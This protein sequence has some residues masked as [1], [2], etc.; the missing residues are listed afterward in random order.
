M[1]AYELN[2]VINRPIEE[3]FTVLSNLENDLKWRTEWVD[4]KKVSEGPIGM[5]TE[6]SLVAKAFGKRI[7][8]IYETIQYEPNRVA[9]W[10]A[11]S[12]P[13]PLTFRRSVERVEGGT[14]LTIR[15]EMELRGFFKLVMPLLAGSVT[16]Q[17]NGDLRKVKELM[18]SRAL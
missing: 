15:Y 10:K 5:G 11:A 4:A 16:R 1:E 14:R 13:I 7:E 6:F 2:T 12:G 9:A 8:T 3:V 17:H 18:E